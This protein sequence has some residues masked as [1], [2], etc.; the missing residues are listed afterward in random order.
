MRRLGSLPLN[1]NETQTT[2]VMVLA[3]HYFSESFYSVR[4]SQ[5]RVAIFIF[6]LQVSLMEADIN[7]LYTSENPS[8][9]IDT[10]HAVM[11]MLF[12]RKFNTVNRTDC[13]SDDGKK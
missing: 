10:Q 13:K 11:T 2:D 5:K 4:M 9:M 7:M 1:V 8:D 3:P 12:G 6:F